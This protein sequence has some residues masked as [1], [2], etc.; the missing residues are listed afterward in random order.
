MNNYTVEYY[1]Y[2]KKQTFKYLIFGILAIVLGVAFVLLSALLINDKQ[3]VIFKIIDSFVLSIALVLGIYC[4][5]ELFAKAK[6]RLKFIYQLLAVS[7]YQGVVKIIK[8]SDKTLIRRGIYGY[9]ITVVDEN[10]KQAIYYVEDKDGLSIDEVIKVTIANNFILEY[11][12]EN[13][14]E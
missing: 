11:E 9:E 7:R 14:H 6:N 5:I 8:I 13:N 3:L 2:L 4:F 12:K 10:K 1:Q